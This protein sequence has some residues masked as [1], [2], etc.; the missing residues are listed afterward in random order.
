[1]PAAPSNSR[2]TYSGPFAE[3]YD[4]ITSH[5]D[6]RAEVEALVQL[7]ERTVPRPSP[8]ILDVGCGTGSHAT[9]VADRGYDVTAIDASADM[10]ARARAKAPA[11]NVVD[12]DIALLDAGQF[13]FAY[14]LYNVVNYLESLEALVGFFS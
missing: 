1:M 11:V 14:S 8:R 4:R 12:G 6:Y 9:L 13:D 3:Y 2:R 5:K 7:V 10:A